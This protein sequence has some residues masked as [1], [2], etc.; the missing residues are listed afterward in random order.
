MQQSIRESFFDVFL[1]NVSSCCDCRLASFY[2]LQSVLQFTLTLKSVSFSFVVVSTKTPKKYISWKALFAC[3]ENEG[4]N[5]RTY[6]NIQR[7][8][9]FQRYGTTIFV[10]LTRKKWN[11]TWVRS[12]LIRILFQLNFLHLQKHTFCEILSPPENSAR[13]M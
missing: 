3:D 12:S 4:T 7:T 11:E 2:K 5:E 6:A 8:V 1:R 10:W 9:N 13:D